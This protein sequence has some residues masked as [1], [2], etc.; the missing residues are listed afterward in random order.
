[1]RI[2]CYNACECPIGTLEYGDTFYFGGTICMR[3][4]PIQNISDCMCVRLD[5]GELQVVPTDTAVI[6]ADTKVVANT[7]DTF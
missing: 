3:V 4:M 1:M 2:D 7:K 6:L 5:S